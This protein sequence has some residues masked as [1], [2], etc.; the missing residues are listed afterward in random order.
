MITIESKKIREFLNKAGKIPANKFITISD[1]VLI[2]ADTVLSLTYTGL[3]GSVKQSFATD[4]QTP[5]SA[6]IDINILGAII[7]NG[8]M[9]TIARKDNCITA[10][11]GKNKIELNVVDAPYTSL[12]NDDSKEQ[13]SVGAE[14]IEAIAEASKV[15]DATHPNPNM[16]NVHVSPVNGKIEIFS[17]NGFSM[18][19][20]EI[21]TD[22]KSEVL[23]SKNMCNAI[24][25]YSDIELSEDDG[26]I[27]FN[28][29][30]TLYAFN[31]PDANRI[32]YRDLLQRQKESAVD[33]GVLNITQ[34]VAFSEQCKKLT[35]NKSF[36]V[37]LNNVSGKAQ[38]VMTDV[39]L[40][41]TNSLE[42]EAALSDGFSMF[43]FEPDKIIPA[44][45]QLN[46]E[47]SIRQTNGHI[48]LSP[49]GDNTTTILFMGKK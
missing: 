25:Q 39:F 17:T 38:A 49:V 10:K 33:N 37:S 4:I 36:D 28:T 30:D 12:L 32:D 21:G 42:L 31:K 8:E 23:L 9:A 5:F 45:K 20:R 40:S 19:V 26:K 41:I 22:F 7:Q 46:G 29:I 24:S 13:Q 48:I 34:L 15:I 6:V 11:C 44:L 2:E 27:Y 1:C 18:F 35:P 3:G 43:S 16:H 14:L 47:V